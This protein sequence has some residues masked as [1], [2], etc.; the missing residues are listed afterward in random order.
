M[1]VKEDGRLWMA[2]FTDDDFTRV[3]IIY[4]ILWT[5]NNFKINKTKYYITLMT[6]QSINIVQKWGP[7]PMKNNYKALKRKNG[8]LASVMTS[9]S[10]RIL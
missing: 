4:Y 5:Y 2:T 10:K 6:P 3:Y 9:S 7:Q 1:K 8:S